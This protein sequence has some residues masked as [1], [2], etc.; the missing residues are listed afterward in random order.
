MLPLELQS[1]P[2][3]LSPI[4]EEVASSPSGGLFPSESDEE[5]VLRTKLAA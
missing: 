1:C 5:I 2:I 4:L 3:S